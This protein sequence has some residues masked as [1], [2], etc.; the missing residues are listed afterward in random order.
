MSGL[1]PPPGV[2]SDVPLARFLTIRTGGSAE[3]FAT[4][5][6]IAE[7]L[8]LLSW[9][10]QAGI[11][12]AVIGSGSNLL[13]A[14]AGVRGLVL[15]LGRE[16]AKIEVEGDRVRCGGAA[17]L[18]AIA[19]RA[20]RAGLAGIEFGVSIPGSVGGAVRMNAGAYGGE[21]AQVLEHA[22]I[23]TAAGIERRGPRELRLAYRSSA[24]ESGSEV[25]TAA[26]FRLRADDPGAIAARIAKLRA[27]RH[28]AQ[29]RGIKT[30]GS[31]FKNPP[32]ELAAG[33]SAGRLLQ[34]AGC[35]GLAIGGARFSE[36][37]ANFIENMGSASTA[38]VIA[39]IEQ[40]R[41]R[42]YE[43]FGIVLDTEVRTLGDLELPGPI[44]D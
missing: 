31:T 23:A 17:R 26:H 43:R 29:P 16:F 39:L 44:G 27:G 9:A 13:V 15:K 18:P 1:Q 14:D 41:R 36:K 38:D 8:E 7:L 2:R 20:A 35:R 12:V 30:F 22:E 3:L 37:H 11:A 42:V 4:P 19:A 33:R 6:S 34:D 24:L 40:G 28:E 10:Q 32:A 25:V 5:R 21:L